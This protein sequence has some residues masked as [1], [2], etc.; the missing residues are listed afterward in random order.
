MNLEQVK[1]EIKELERSPAAEKMYPITSSWVP[2]AD[3]LAILNRFE[4]HWKRFRDEK[5]S[6]EEVK[7]I[8]EILGES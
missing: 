4:K 2:V 5:K 3:V 7:M 8:T 1:R 6:R